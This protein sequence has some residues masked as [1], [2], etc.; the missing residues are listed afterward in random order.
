MNNPVIKI[1]RTGRPFEF[2]FEFKSNDV[3][4]VTG[5]LLSKLK[6]VNQYISV[7]FKIVRVSLNLYSISKEGT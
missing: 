7:H 4:T 6:F 3:V 5:N 1:V 2:R